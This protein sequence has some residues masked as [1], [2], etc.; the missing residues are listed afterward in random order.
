MELDATNAAKKMHCERSLTL[1]LEGD[2]LSIPQNRKRQPWMSKNEA[3]LTGI[4]GDCEATLKLLK[5]KYIG[6]TNG[7]TLAAFRKRYLNK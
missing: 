3:A 2:D 1:F 4:R 7:G 5:L 6:I